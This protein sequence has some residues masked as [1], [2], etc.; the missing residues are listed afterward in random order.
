M[1]LSSVELWQRIAASQ[2]ASPMLC[3]SWA[4]DA[5][6]ALSASEALDAE[7]VGEQ[8]VMQGK[9]TQFQ[10][11]TLLGDTKLPL[12]RNG[13]R[14]LE[15]VNY[16]AYV[17]PHVRSIWKEWWAVAKSPSSPTLWMRWIQADEFKQAAL[18][19]SKPRATAC[20]ATI[21]NKA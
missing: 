3:R 18:A 9:L 20:V 8:L 12:I 19:Q 10:V 1:G 6:T 16:A 7:R 13:Y 15:P 17:A 21:A 11:E 4:A 2:L 14:L 5:A